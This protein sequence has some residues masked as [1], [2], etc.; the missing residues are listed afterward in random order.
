MKLVRCQL[1]VSVLGTGQMGTGIASLLVQ[2][3]LVNEIVWWGRSIESL[4]TSYVRLKKE[5]RRFAKTSDYSQEELLSKLTLSNDLSDLRDSC[6][7]IEAVAEDINLKGKLLA[8]V[9]ELLSEE[10]IVASNTSSLSITALSM[11]LSN[12]EN[13]IGMHFFNPTSVMELVEIVRGLNTSDI[14]IEKAVSFAKSLNKKPVLVNESPGFI[15]NRMLIP[16]INEA[17]SVFAEGVASKEDIDM[18]MKLGANHPLGPL[19]LADLIGTDV[20]LSIM[21]SLHNE[22]GDPKY[23]AHPL[24]RQYVRAGYKGRKVGRGFYVYK[25]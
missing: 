12:P 3:E 17:V 13:V 14:V 21:E 16:M 18:A 4:E 6:F 22:T 20:C 24:L 9:S 5:V 7:C 23:R 19:A 11:N 25:R 1:K 15:V 10:C 8:N 2:S